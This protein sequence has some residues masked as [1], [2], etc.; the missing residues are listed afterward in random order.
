MRMT[1][2]SASFQDVPIGGF[3]ASARWIDSG[4]SWA[5]P[6]EPVNK[7]AFFRKSLLESGILSGDQVRHHAQCRKHY[8]GVKKMTPEALVPLPQEGR[9]KGIFAVKANLIHNTSFWF[10]NSH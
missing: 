6:A 1:M 2:C 10:L 7:A 3:I 5:R 4:S 9:R 8:D